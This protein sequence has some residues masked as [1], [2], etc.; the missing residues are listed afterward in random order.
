MR[1]AGPTFVANEDVWPEQDERAASRTSLILA[2]RAGRGCDM[3][4]LIDVRWLTH[5]AGV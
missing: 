2:C 1:V 4:H 3:D 5:A